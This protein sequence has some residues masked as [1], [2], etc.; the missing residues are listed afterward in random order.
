MQMQYKQPTVH[1]IAEVVYPR[2]ALQI[3]RHT[4]L[5][6]SDKAPCRVTVHSCGESSGLAG[7][8]ASG[9]HC[10]RMEASRP[11]LEGHGRSETH[12]LRN[13]KGCLIFKRNGK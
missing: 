10:G 6:Q 3:S 1:R 13:V 5:P 8:P 4:H 7:R 12:F 9:I 11:P 2:S